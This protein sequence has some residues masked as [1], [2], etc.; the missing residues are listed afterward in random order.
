MSVIRILTLLFAVLFGL[1]VAGVIHA[2]W[3]LVFSPFLLAAGLLVLLCAVVVG[4][5]I[6]KAL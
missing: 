5:A 1:K 4:A 2:S 6:V 3:L